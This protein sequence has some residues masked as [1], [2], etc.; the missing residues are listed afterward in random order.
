[1][2][3]E[4]GRRERSCCRLLQQKWKGV[5]AGGGSWWRL[6]QAAAGCCR[7]LLRFLQEFPAGLV[8][9]GETKNSETT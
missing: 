5:W 8:G 2:D 3:N 7:L 1:M 9:N 6:L 4:T